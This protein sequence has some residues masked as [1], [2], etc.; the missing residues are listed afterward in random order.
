MATPPKISVVMTCHNHERFVGE[1][2]RSILS[3]TEQDF[4]LVIVDD[5]SSDNTLKAIREFPDPRII[6][7]EQENS[8]PSIALNTG[9]DKSQGQYVAF[10]SGGDVSLPNRLMTQKGQIELQKADIV[11]CLPQIIGPNSKILG[12]SM[13]HGFFHRDFK[14]TAEL[15]RQL[16]Y[17]GNFL[18]ASSFFSRRTAIEKV[19][20]FKRGLAQLQDFDYWIRACK[21]DLMIMLHNEQLVQYRCLSGVNSS[22]ELDKFRENI[23]TLR[24]YR[25]FFDDT[26]FDFLSKAFDE[27]IGLAGQDQDA[28]MDID[29]SFL[30]LDHVT[31]AIRGIGIE[32][33]I[34]QLEDHEIYEKLKAER[35]FDTAKLFALARSGNINSANS[36]GLRKSGLPYVRNFL[37]RILLIAISERP[38]LTP[39]EVEQ[40]IQYFLDMGDNKRAIMLAHGFKSTPAGPM[41]IARVF[42]LTGKILVKVRRS[43]QK[44]KKELAPPRVLEGVFSLKRMY[45]YSKERNC[46]VHED[47]AEKVYLRR[48]K[49]TGHFTGLLGEGETFC[50]RVYVSILTHATI[51]AGSSLVISQSGD[52]LSDE[53]VDFSSKDFGVKSPYVSFRNN[54]KAILTYRKKLNTHIKEGI[55]LSC[56]HD[57]NYFHW[58]IEC[59]PK[60]LLIDDLKQYNDVPLLIHSGLHENLKAALRRVNVTCHP[61][62]HLEDGVAYHVDRLVFPSAL[63]RVVDRYLGRAVFDSDIV[64]S[65]RWISK[66][67]NVLKNNTRKKRKPWRKVYLERKK[68]L[69]SLSNQDEIELVLRKEKIEIIAMDCAT[70]ESQIDFFSQVSVLIAPTGAALTNMLFCQPGTKVIIFMSDHESTNYYFWSH[71]GDIAKLDVSIILG[72]RQFARTDKYSVHDD[73]AIDPNILLEEIKSLAHSKF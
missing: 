22:E 53:M 67:A 42:N 48:P 62:V 5:G 3:Q 56:D 1:A 12:D 47:P 43:L 17:F 15:F 46:I 4:E 20:K 58:L 32:R 23:E 9:I 39:V 21:K 36:I 49:V 25:S 66:V 54:N 16:F 34:V 10:L 31:P 11:F 29:K 57:N 37:K 59:L 38:N 61:I 19:G 30:F 41:I 26:R 24:V 7:V 28:D 2:I 63:S 8:G 70:L 55:L 40:R 14:S 73:Y 71:L 69:R 45:D 6:V 68:S 13:C 18:C 50:P 52:L 51:T 33:L 72:E 60:L 27:K 35:D 64:F 44:V 65:A